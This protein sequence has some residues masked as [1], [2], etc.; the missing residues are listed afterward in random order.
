M[1]QIDNWFDAYLAYVTCVQRVPDGWSAQNARTRSQDRTGSQRAIALRRR[2]LA[3]VQLKRQRP[4]DAYIACSGVSAL[5][6]ATVFCCRRASLLLCVH[7]VFALL[8]RVRIVRTNA[9]THA[10]H[11]GHKCGPV[12]RSCPVRRVPYSPKTI[13][14]ISFGRTSC[15][16]RGFER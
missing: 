3:P 8:L 10:T 12:E 15:I 11:R 13:Q 16:A 9:R 7:T 5:A 4:G 2:A 1:H 6:S 14:H